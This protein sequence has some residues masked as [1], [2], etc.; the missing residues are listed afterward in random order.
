M[1]KLCEL[2]VCEETIR[3]MQQALEQQKEREGK[4]VEA[5]KFISTGCLVPP[6]GGCPK[7]EDAVETAEA[8]LKELGIL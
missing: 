8:T 5:L 6:D 7:L 2:G 4:L 1:D 3:D